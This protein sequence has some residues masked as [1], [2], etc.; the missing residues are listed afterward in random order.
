[1][2]LQCDITMVL[3]LYL[4]NLG[5]GRSSRLLYLNDLVNF[6][7]GHYL[8]WLPCLL[9]SISDSFSHKCMHIHT[10]TKHIVSRKLLAFLLTPLPCCNVFRQHP[11]PQGS[12]GI[13]TPHSSH[14]HFDN[15]SKKADMPGSQMDI[16]SAT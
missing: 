8:Y 5:C 13:Y 15:L 6:P 10:H 4:C 1:M 2:K 12:F 3:L 11:T 7:L 9:M 14:R 16:R